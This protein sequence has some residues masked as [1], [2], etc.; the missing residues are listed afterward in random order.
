MDYREI[1]ERMKE[2]PFGSSAFQIQHFIA[3]QKTPERQY[4]KVLLQ[5]DSKMR[6][7]KDCEFRR[8][9]KEIEIDE[10]KYK[11]SN[12]DAN[13][14]EQSFKIRKLEIDL[15]K[16]DYLLE[17]EIKLIED[18]MIEIK[19]Y[20]KIIEQ[21]PRYTREDFEKAEELYWTQRLIGDAERERLANGHVSVGTITA[22]EQIG[23]VMNRDTHGH[24]IWSKGEY[25]Y[26]MLG[27]DLL[28]LI[29]GTKIETVEQAN[30][31]N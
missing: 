20:E 13:D 8:R 5:L 10:I 29:D 16:A 2:V 4:Q 19:I 31:K 28:K 18:C 21:L 25:Q 12:L 7:M 6:A 26:K 11:L 23:V 24:I 14:R 27:A 22:L 1:E 15:E 17:H 9:K 30:E 3:E